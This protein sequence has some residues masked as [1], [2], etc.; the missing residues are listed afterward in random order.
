[1]ATLRTRACWLWILLGLFALR[2][3]GQLLVALGWAP[4]LP[5]MEEWF[6]GILAY[7]MLLAS[8]AMIL[9]LY[10]KV[11]LDFTRGQGYFV[12]PRRRLGI[13]L[14]WFGTIYLI[15]M[16][17]RYVLRMSLH[18]EERWLGGAIPIIF[19]WV[20]A[21]FLLTVGQYHWSHT[22]HYIVRPRAGD[23]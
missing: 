6:S 18:P 23:N 21:V 11:C 13:G 9:I 20:L 8:Q 4:F 3:V 1:M 22:R 16:I 17:I 12:V 14:L 2:V 10:A 7:P 15:A 5:P 19:H